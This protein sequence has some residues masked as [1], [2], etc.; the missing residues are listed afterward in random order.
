VS[1]AENPI[2]SFPD[3]H[4]VMT[5]GPPLSVRDRTYRGEHVGCKHLLRAVARARPLLHC[6]G[7]IHELSSSLLISH[8]LS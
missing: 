3:V 2:P 6:F 7:H 8:T 1:I 5:H 4:V